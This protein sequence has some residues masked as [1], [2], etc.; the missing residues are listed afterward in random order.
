MLQRSSTLFGLLLFKV[1]ERKCMS[2][3]F[4]RKDPKRRAVKDVREKVGTDVCVCVC[5]CVSCGINS[6]SRLG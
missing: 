1:L 3:I 4:D 5:V 6:N 2:S